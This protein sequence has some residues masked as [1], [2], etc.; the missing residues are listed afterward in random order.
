MLGYRIW[1]THKLIRKRAIVKF[2]RDVKTI[3]KQQDKNSSCAQLLEKR[4][5]SFHAHT[6]HADAFSV[7]AKIT[8]IRA[9]Q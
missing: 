9:K 4:I 3:L 6:K 5:K 2:K 1:P 7:T 8:N